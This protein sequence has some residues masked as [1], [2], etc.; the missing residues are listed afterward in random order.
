MD[1]SLRQ[2]RSDAQQPNG[3]LAKLQ[4]LGSILNWLASLFQLTEEEQKNAG[5]YFGG[6]RM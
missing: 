6:R 5:I 3:F 4:I 1:D 2:Q